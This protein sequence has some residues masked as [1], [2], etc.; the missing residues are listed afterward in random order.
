M[1]LAIPMTIT[2]IEGNKAVAESMGVEKTIDVS[3]TPEVKLNDKVIIHAGF[4]I[5]ILDPETAKEIEQTWD[6]YIKTMESGQ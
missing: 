6:E 1:C 4:V 3:L 5:E 2:K